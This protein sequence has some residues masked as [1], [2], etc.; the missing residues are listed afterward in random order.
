MDAPVY[1]RTSEFRYSAA[2][3]NHR[4]ASMIER[5]GDQRTERMSGM[6]LGQ[7]RQDS[8][9]ARSQATPGVGAATHRA[10]FSAVVASLR[11]SARQRLRSVSSKARSEESPDTWLAP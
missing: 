3:K 9:P 2:D 7:G 11:P 4:P 5:V 6:P 8:C 10:S 1:A